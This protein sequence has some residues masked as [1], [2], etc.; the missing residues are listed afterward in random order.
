MSTEEKDSKNKEKVSILEA[1]SDNL[2]AAAF[3]IFL[4]LLGFI[5]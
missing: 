4:V 3:F 5:A 2:L 1:W